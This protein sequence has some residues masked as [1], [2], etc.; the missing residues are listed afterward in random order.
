[1]LKVYK[2]LL[3]LTCLVLPNIVYANIQS[4]LAA[5]TDPVQVTKSARDQGILP[6]VAVS[7]LISAG[8][9]S[10]KAVEIVADVYGLSDNCGLP[11]DKAIE[12]MVNA[13]VNNTM[14]DQIVSDRCGTGDC[15]Q[16]IAPIDEIIIAAL[17]SIEEG[18]DEENYTLTAMFPGC[19]I[20][21][22]ENNGFATKSNLTSAGGGEVSP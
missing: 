16:T 18:N 7:E 12:E 13:G 14:A 2:I 5:G 17:S 20:A 10:S 19:N 1:M 9:E 22:L 6:D 4:E 15:D 11:R 3:V 8:L 21:G